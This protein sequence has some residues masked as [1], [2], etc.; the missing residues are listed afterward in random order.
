M[1]LEVITVRLQ[2]ASSDATPYQITRLYELPIAR[3]VLSRK[4]YKTRESSLIEQPRCKPLRRS[5]L[6]A[7]F[8]N[9]FKTAHS[10]LNILRKITYN[11][12]VLR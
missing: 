11:K 3:R 4:D 6:S 5:A 12:Y 7:L 1:F 2:Y 8:A 10:N 9:V